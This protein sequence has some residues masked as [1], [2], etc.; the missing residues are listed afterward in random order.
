MGSRLH[1]S[2]AVKALVQDEVL[3]GPVARQV[4]SGRTAARFMGCR[5]VGL[6]LGVERFGC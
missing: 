6:K 3:P 5:L 1:E 4:A 2:L